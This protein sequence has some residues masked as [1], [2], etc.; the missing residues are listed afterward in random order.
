[1]G[2]A[3]WIERATFI[4]DAGI[5]MISNP[6]KHTRRQAE[7]IALLYKY[8]TSDLVQQSGLA[9][10]FASATQT[11]NN[12]DCFD[13]TGLRSADSHDWSQAGGKAK[14]QNGA[15]A[16]ATEKATSPKNLA[17]DLEAM[18]P[19]FIKLGQLLS[20]R[21]DFLPEPYLDALSKLQDDA[22]P[23]APQDIFRIIEEE[24]GQQPEHLF[25]SFNI[26][27]LA[28]ASLGQVHRATMH[29]GKKVVVK[30]QRPG[31]VEQLTSDI[32]AMEGLASVSENFAFARKYQLN[33]LVESLKQSLAMEVDY[34]NEASNAIELT[35][36]LCDFPTIKI[37]QPIQTHSTRRVLT[38]EYVDCE[39]ITDMPPRR[40]DKTT[41]SRL[42]NELFKSFLYQVLVHGAFHAD[43]HPG[44][45]ALTC[46]NQIVL[47]DHGLVVKVPQT[48][49]S[50]L[51]KLLIAISDGDG[52]QAAKIAQ[53]CGIAGDNFSE[54]EFKADIERIVAANI[55]QNV[56]QLDSGAALMEIQ[57]AAGRH[58]IF[59]PQEVILLGRTLMHLERVVSAL[60]SEFDPNEAIRTHAMEIMREH[61]GKKLTL[62]S[63]YQAFM[64]STEFAQ[65]LP[66]RA[67]KFADLVTNNEI[68]IKVDAF[69][70]TK[71]I[72]GLNKVANRI[73][74]GLVIS[75]MIVA[76]AL[77]MRIEGG[78]TVFGYPLIAFVFLMMAG[79]A[80]SILVWRVIVSDRFEQ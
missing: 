36:N 20:T 40:L 77:M 59:L 10:K 56:N 3:Y 53:S 62:A 1:M 44:N 73:S 5:Q 71:F 64:E 2:N 9:E 65:Q 24:L 52:A 45:V 72:S 51:I 69:D 49:Q 57:Q 4:T 70:E 27:P 66:A 12:S 43:P 6:L 55:N 60:D 15:I 7:M 23:I 21:P 35:D 48:L 58:D 76:A 80:G 22:K 16:T 13:A 33:H 50:D 41:S 67:N 19:A 38:M 79:V 29:D 25:A 18:G 68:Q 8:G 30:V 14:P 46:E 75:A 63:L 42:A 74:T 54:V 34:E 28:T 78:P 32:E 11:A 37:P 17:E 47:M 39:K 31:V 61:S 26:E